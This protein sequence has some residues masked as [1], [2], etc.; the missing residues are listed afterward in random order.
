MPGMNLYTALG[1]SPI[2]SQ[3]QAQTIPDGRSDRSSALPSNNYDMPT[4]AGFAAQVARR[5]AHTG[6]SLQRKP[7][8][9][10]GITQSCTNLPRIPS[11]GAV[12]GKH[13]AQHQWSQASETH[14][15]PTGFD[16]E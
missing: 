6:T 12:S 14:P 1:K 3:L 7:P 11:A 5:P 4:Q 2:P 15:D 8:E 10:L 16:Q 9:P 13:Q